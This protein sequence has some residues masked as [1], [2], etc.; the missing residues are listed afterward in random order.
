MANSFFQ[1]KQ[2]RIDQGL[3]GMKVTTDAC[4]FG[5]LVAKEIKNKAEPAS[6]L[7]IGTGTGLLSLMLAQS[8]LNSHIHA[9]EI[10]QDAFTQ[11]SFNFQNAPW[12]ERLAIEQSAFQDFNS[13][14]KFDLIIS[15]P[16]FF[17]KNQLGESA[18]K[19][20]AV[21]NDS[22]S[23]DQLATGVVNHLSKD[24]ELFLLYPPFEMGLFIEAGTRLNLFPNKIFDIKDSASKKVIRQA[25]LFSSTQNK[26]QTTELVIKQNDGNYTDAFI[27]LLKPYYLH[28]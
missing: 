22:L 7:D 19:N 18:K 28:L 25:V 16:P 11:A 27:D 24:G 13:D 2:F 21:H 20:L 6:I 15:N 14:P 9:L 26:V 4:L 8:S 3:C 17:S 5:A 10:D 23:I 1:F 12:S